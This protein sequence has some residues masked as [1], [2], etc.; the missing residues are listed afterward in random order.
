MTIGKNKTDRVAVNVFVYNRFPGL[1]AF[2]LDNR[3]LRL[4]RF[5][6]RLLLKVFLACLYVQVDPDPVAI[7][8]RILR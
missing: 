1:V 7:K 2:T 8:P 4:V 5:Y 6:L 3:I